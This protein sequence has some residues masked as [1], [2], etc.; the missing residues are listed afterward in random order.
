MKSRIIPKVSV[1]NADAPKSVLVS[2]AGGGGG[3]GKEGGRGPPTP[4]NIFREYVD[5]QGRRGGHG[6]TPAGTGVLR[7]EDT[8][9]VDG[10]DKALSITLEDWLR[11]STKSCRD[12]MVLHSLSDRVGRAAVATSAEGTICESSVSH[13]SSS[14]SPFLSTSGEELTIRTS[15]G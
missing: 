15:D 12:V 5:E 9:L 1:R 4:F 11:N 8:V 13:F 10:D 14:L 6:E 2:V 3:V 7:E